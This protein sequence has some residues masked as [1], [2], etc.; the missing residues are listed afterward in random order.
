M[1]APLPSFVQ[2]EPVG[3]CN[4]RCRMCPIQFR[5]DG[6]PYGPPAFMP[7]DTF[8]RLVDQFIGLKELHLQGMG[9]PLMHPRFFD[10]VSYAA[11]KDIRVSTNTNLT[12]LRPRLAE[13]CIGSGLDSVHVSLDGATA[14][15]YERIRVGARFRCVTRNLELLL[16]V[17]RRLGTAGPRIALVMVVMRQN[18]HELPE[19]V[20]LAHGWSVSE[21]FVQHLC[22]DFGESSLPPHY[23]SMREFVQAETLLEED[24]QRIDRYFSEARESADRLGVR[25]R[26]PRIRPR[27][28]P[29]GTPGRM[30]CDWPW[31]GCYLSYRGDAM[32]CCMVATPDRLHFGNAAECGVDAI[33]NGEMYEAFRQ[34]LD[35]DDPP[36]ICRSCSIY[37]GTF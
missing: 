35:S 6:P 3:Q 23:R 20:R 18:L 34:Q 33:W 12:L 37:K 2:I 15:T 14:E 36:E 17:R 21:V 28:H 22:H 29:S 1:T 7:Y 27:L 8:T 25:L 32:P 31:R 26:L 13:Q 19:V 11:Q 10:M 30:R 5:Q 9:E 16:A 4:L 24:P